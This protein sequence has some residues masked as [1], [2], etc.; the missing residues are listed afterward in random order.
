VAGGRPCSTAHE[1]VSWRGPSDISG[2]DR[3]GA[4]SEHGSHVRDGE[5]T[6]MPKM[7]ERK[8]ANLESW[9]RNALQQAI[10]AAEV[11]AAEIPDCPPA[12]LP[13]TVA[14]FLLE[15][16]WGK[17][18]MGDAHNYFGIK[19]RPGEPFVT[20]STK[21]FV[22]GVEKR[23][24][25]QFRAYGSM[26]ECFADHARLLCQRT[27]KDGRKIYA[28]A[29]AHPD[30]PRAFARALTGVYATDPAYGQKLVSIM[31]SRGLLETFGFQ[32]V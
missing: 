26:A 7:I 29:L 28:A 22:G 2:F 15:S 24:D 18:G 12:L 14:Q 11:A 25:A 3:R 4:R 31:E 27:R 1:Q 20:K 10:D 30:D 17:A 32:T 19:A 5:D 8:N 21:E 6:H 23:M 13:V 16:N 9:K